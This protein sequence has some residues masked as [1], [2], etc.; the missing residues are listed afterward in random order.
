MCQSFSQSILLLTDRD[1]LITRQLIAGYPIELVAEWQG[2]SSERVRQLFERATY[3]IKKRHVG[4]HEEIDNLRKDNARLKEENLLLKDKLYEKNVTDI[5]NIKK[6]IG[7]IL[8]LEAKKLK[9]STRTQNVLESLSVDIFGQIPTLDV[10]ELLATPNCGKKTIT[11]IQQLLKKVNLNLGMSA[12]KVVDIL[13]KQD[14]VWVREAI[15]SSEKES[16][17]NFKECIEIPDIN[18]PIVGKITKRTPTDIMEANLKNGLPKKHGLK[19]SS[20]DVEHIKYE[21]ARGCTVRDIA[22][23]AQRTRGSIIAKLTQVLGSDWITA[24]TYRDDDG[25]VHLK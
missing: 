18:I 19:W 1:L 7:A 21:Y 10:H 22:I 4:L 15:Q 16:K 3:R 20:S 5:P 25:H 11:E 24:D 8:H 13:E 12:I 14:L 23:S 17:K 6:E 9:L 2:V